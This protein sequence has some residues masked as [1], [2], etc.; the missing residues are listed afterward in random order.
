MSLILFSS[1]FLQ[2]FSCFSNFYLN[3]LFKL[4]YNLVSPSVICFLQFS[5]VIVSVALSNFYLLFF[6]FNENFF[7]IFLKLNT[8]LLCISADICDHSQML[9]RTPVNRSTHENACFGECANV[10]SHIYCCKL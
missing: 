5:F 3:L 7:T 2:K 1:I 9:V 10:Y 8:F 6:K 4:F